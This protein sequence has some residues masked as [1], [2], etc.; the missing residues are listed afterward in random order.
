MIETDVEDEERGLGLEWVFVVA[1]A[2]F[3]GVDDVGVSPTVLLLD[4]EVDVTV[5]F[6]GFCFVVDVCL[7]REEDARVD[8]SGAAP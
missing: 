8:V 6:A 1:V 7:F 4:S 2:S 5:S 3:C